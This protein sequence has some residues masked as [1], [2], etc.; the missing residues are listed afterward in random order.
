MVWRWWLIG[1]Y[2]VLLWLIPFAASCF[3]FDKTGKLWMDKTA[4]KSLMMVLSASVGTAAFWS[5]VRQ[6]LYLDAD[7]LS[8]LCVTSGFVWLGI[9]YALDL[10]VLLP[11]GQYSLLVWFVEIGVRYMPMPLTG[12]LL[13]EAIRMAAGLKEGP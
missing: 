12:W 10:L 3:C 9:N 4:F 11:M 6:H 2:G 8:A 7:S 5:L 1:L 13:G